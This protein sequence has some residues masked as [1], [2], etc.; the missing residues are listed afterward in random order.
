MQSKVCINKSHNYFCHVAATKRRRYPQRTMKNATEY[1]MIVLA[2]RDADTFPFIALA[3]QI[4]GQWCSVES[5]KSVAQ[6]N[7]E[8]AAAF[9][10]A[11][12]T[13]GAA[14]DHGPVKLVSYGHGLRLCRAYCK[15][16][17]QAI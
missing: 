6:L 11:L 4:D 17:E 9:L 8:S 5:R 1:R 2:D 14:T 12:A 16:T 13:T 7:E 15:A 3:K 10:L